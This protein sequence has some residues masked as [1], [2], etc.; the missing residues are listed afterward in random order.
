MQGRGIG[1]VWS[2]GG[3]TAGVGYREVWK[4]CRQE[5]ENDVRCSA[6][7]CGWCGRERGRVRTGVAG[8][9]KDC[10]LANF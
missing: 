1:K 10:A 7:M 6:G 8:S 9:K 4:W 5:C 3:Y 2:P